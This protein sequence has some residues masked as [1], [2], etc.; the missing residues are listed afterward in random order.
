MKVSAKLFYQAV[1]LIGATSYSALTSAE[2]SVSIRAA[3]YDRQFSNATSTRVQTGLSLVLRHQQSLMDDRLVITGAAYAAQKLAANGL[4][5][6]D[7]LTLVNGKLSGFSLIGEASI[8]YKLIGG[9]EVEVGRVRHQSLFLQSKTRL[10]A[11]TFEG[12]NLNWQASENLDIYAHRFSKWSPRANS[13]F[14]RFS[15]QRSEPGA[16]AKLIIV[17][18][19]A[20]FRLSQSRKLTVN[21][22]ILEADNYLRKLGLVATFEQTTNELESI[23]LEAAILSSNDAGSLFIEGS[24]SSLDSSSLTQTYRQDHDG[25]GAYFAAHYGIKNHTLGLTVSQFGDTWIE[26]NFEGDHGT[27]PFPTRTFGPELTNKNETVWLA[28]YKYSWKLGSLRG[29]STKLAY[30]K[31]IGAENSIDR[32]LGQAREN[33]W[34]AELRYRAPWANGFETRARYRD[35]QSHISGEVVGV[36]SNRSELRLDISYKLTF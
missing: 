28:D 29:L 17:G 21:S 32:E 27:T 7:L 35:Y 24:N 14:H 23:E 31:G 26:D 20:K 8:A 34:Y 3:H 5:R 13:K 33:W 36:T 30:A 12:V 22:E 18:V 1:Y 19:D 2:T 10:L 4:L 9:I 16:I 6:E 11:S 25:L 15:T